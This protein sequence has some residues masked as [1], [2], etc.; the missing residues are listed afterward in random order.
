MIDT[1][2]TDVVGQNRVDTTLWRTGHVIEVAVV[3]SSTID[4][5]CNCSEGYPSIKSSHS[6]TKQ[7]QHNFNRSRSSSSS[8][9]SS[10]NQQQQSHERVAAQKPTSLEGVGVSVIVRDLV[11]VCHTT[12]QLRNTLALLL[13]LSCLMHLV[14][15]IPGTKSSG[16]SESRA[17]T[18]SSGQGEDEQEHA[19]CVSR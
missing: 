19:C 18:D 6:S 4:T 16:Y 13:R 15:L 11:V 1:E 3:R 8:G 10:C 5:Y 14:C 2:C 7:Q 9:G 17:T 12:G